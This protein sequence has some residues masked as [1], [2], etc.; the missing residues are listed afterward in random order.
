MS[1][2]HF[3]LIILASACAAVAFAQTQQNASATRAAV[4]GRVTDAATG[5]AIDFADVVITDDENNTI[6]STAV[7]DGRSP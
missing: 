3:L 6:A 1:M 4:S 7:R 5:A 2:K